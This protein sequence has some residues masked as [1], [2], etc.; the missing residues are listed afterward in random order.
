LVS[1]L[2][3]SILS[4]TKA[5]GLMRL[6]AMMPGGMILS[7][8]SL[9]MSFEQTDFASRVRGADSNT[10]I[11]LVHL[12]SSPSVVYTKSL[13]TEPCETGRRIILYETR[14][15]NRLVG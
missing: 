3:A 15:S 14:N 11:G 8:N 12:V 7:L 5:R 10:N 4:L 2:S 13:F 9:M 6:S 1:L